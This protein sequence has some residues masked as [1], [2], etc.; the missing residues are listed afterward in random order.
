MRAE[1]TS[2][3][4]L[5]LKQAID[6]YGAET[7]LLRHLNRNEV[8]R[9]LRT[10]GEAHGISAVAKGTELSRPTVDLALRDLTERGLVIESVQHPSSP[11]GGRP[12]RE[13]RFDARSGCVAAVTVTNHEVLVV[14][15]DLRDQVL[16]ER[17]IRFADLNAEPDP[18]AGLR[19]AVDDALAGCALPPERLRVAVIGVRGIVSDGGVI[20]TSG[21]LPS[22]VGEDVHRRL[23]DSFPC[24]LLVEND[25]NLAT[26]AEFSALNGP[27]NV[28]GLLIGE[29]MGCGLVLNGEL[30]RGA[31]G[32]AGEFFGDDRSRA[33]SATNQAIRHHAK[34]HDLT[35]TEVFVAARQ[36]RGRARTLVTRYATDIAERVE[37]LLVLD[38]P[39]IVV[40][41]EIVEAGEVFMDAFRAALAPVLYSD[42]KIIYSDLGA[43]CLRAGALQ[44]AANWTAHHLFQV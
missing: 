4:T 28:V 40:G 7:S 30:Y 10:S 5:T 12:A 24:P 1:E 32:A 13:Y 33:W 20:L 17:R 37:G 41:G 15:A 21:E 38:P 6:V 35:F 44:V 31:H 26:L 14:I 18:P 29:G 34:D 23:R 8:L 42:T 27:S 9:F 2:P 22:L 39:V 36:K 16:D 3:P 19:A 43:D 11:R 25:A